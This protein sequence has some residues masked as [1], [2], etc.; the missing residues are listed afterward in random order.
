MTSGWWTF[1]TRKIPAHMLFCDRPRCSSPKTKRLTK[2]SSVARVYGRCFF[3]P[4]TSVLLGSTPPPRS[5]VR[6]GPNPPFG[7]ALWRL[8]GEGE[9]LGPA[10]RPRRGGG[11]AVPGHRLSS[12]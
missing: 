6:A 11:Q 12:R 3:D 2:T 10:G 1:L 8:A 4:T 5:P 9:A 7:A